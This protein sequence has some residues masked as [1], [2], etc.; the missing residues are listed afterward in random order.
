M[1]QG[2]IAKKAIDIIL[3]KV[4]EKREV[5]KLR[6]YVEEDNELDIQVKQ[7]Q[8]TISKQGKYIEELEKNVAI[9]K[10]D[11]HPPAFSKKSYNK[12]LKRLNKIEKEC[13]CLK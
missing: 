10:S 5:K 4:M 9:L 7:M 6:K 11:S 2:L 13:P 1:I 3:K 12:I 8:K